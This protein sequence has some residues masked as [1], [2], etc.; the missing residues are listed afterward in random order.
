MT[1][2]LIPDVDPN[3]FWYVDNDKA[4][5]YVNLGQLGKVQ[6]SVTTK[7]LCDKAFE[8][9]NFSVEDTRLYN[10]FLEKLERSELWAEQ[11]FV[12]ALIFN[13]IACSQFHKEIKSKNWYYLDNPLPQNTELL[14]RIKSKYAETQVMIL[15]QE[16]AYVT[17]VLLSSLLLDETKTLPQFSLQ[18][19][20][21]E[22]LF[23]F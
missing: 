4:S 14:M 5:L 19:L 2:R 6:T 7:L 9:R 20:S 18:K 15:A 11:N 13:A 12:F 21:V 23:A 1:D 16:K 22:K 17:V 3:W 8:S 10:L